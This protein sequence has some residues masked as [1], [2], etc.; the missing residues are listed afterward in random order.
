MNIHRVHKVENNGILKKTFHNIIN[1]IT[2]SLNLITRRLHGLLDYN[3]STCQFKANFAIVLDK[4]SVGPFA[5]FLWQSCLSFWWYYLLS[6]FV[7][8]LTCFWWCWVFVYELSGCWF[9]SIC[10][11]EKCYLSNSIFIARG[12][13]APV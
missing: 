2:K 13:V 12:G 3:L 10:S 6:D 9:E 11:H 4:N 8:V 1:N 7:S 5:S